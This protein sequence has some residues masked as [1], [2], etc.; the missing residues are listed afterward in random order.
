MITQDG[1]IHR[2][3][4]YMHT[5]SQNKQHYMKVFFGSFSKNSH[6]SWFDPQTKK[7]EPHCKTKQTQPLQVKTQTLSATLQKC[8]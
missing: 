3:K 6:T 5:V 4:S 1:L 2:V 7:L 8:I